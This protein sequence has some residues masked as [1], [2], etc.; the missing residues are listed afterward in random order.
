[1]DSIS[2]PKRDIRKVKYF[3]ELSKETQNK[4]LEHLRN[5]ELGTMPKTFI[6]TVSD[7]LGIPNN[8]IAELFSTVMSLVNSK[9]TIDLNENDF[10]DMILASLNREEDLPLESLDIIEILKSFTENSNENIYI[11]LEALK[12]NGDNSRIYIDSKFH[13]EI[14]PVFINNLHEG[15]LCIHV[16]KLEYRENDENK[17]FYISL[18]LDDLKNLKDNIEKA[19]KEL[20]LLKSSDKIKI[21]DFK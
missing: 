5:F 2:I 18:D 20:N 3:S 4:F 13:S 11:T 12:I 8:E 17:F 10:Y 9:K 21:F 15:N 19:E 16:L 7:D 1:M 14:R 6:E